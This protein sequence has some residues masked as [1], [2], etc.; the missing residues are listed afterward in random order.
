MFT[1]FGLF[2]LQESLYAQCL[3]PISIYPFQEDFEAGPAG[4]VSGGT[5]SDWVL[6]T[7]S[8]PVIANA[9]SGN[10]CW[11]T[12]GL[13]TSFYSYGERSWVMSPCFDLSTLT[14]PV[15]S[16]SAFWDTEYLYD[17][18]NFQYSIDGGNS[19]RTLGAFS[20]PDNCLDQNWYNVNSVT[21][22]SGITNDNQGWAGTTQNTSGSCRG[23]HGSGQWMEAKHCLAV[24]AGQS[25]VLFR[26][27][28]GSG[29]TCNDYDGFAFDLFRIEE[30]TAVPYNFTWHCVANNVVQFNDTISTCHTYWN[31]NFGDPGSSGNTSNLQSPQHTYSAPGTYSVTLFAGNEC[32]PDVSASVS[33]FILDITTTSTPETCI[34]AK[35]GTAAVQVIGSPSVNLYTWNTDPIQ[36]TATATGLGAG[37]YAV[38]ITTANACDVD[39]TVRVEIGPDAFPVVE[40]GNDTTLCPGS[41]I[42]L[43]A[44]NFQAYKWQ[45]SSAQ[46]SFVV[47]SGGMYSVR[48]TNSA[49]CTTSDSIFISE[50]CLNELV[51]PNAFTPNEDGINEIFLP[52]GSEVSTY[53]LRIFNRWGQLIFETDD[54]NK[55]WDGRFHGRAQQDGIYLYKVSYGIR[56][57]EEKARTGKLVLI[58]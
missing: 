54:Q 18:A 45:D 42:L 27:T 41:S 43:Q 31:W 53:D 28:F 9:A 40:L 29:T 57:G 30:A 26:F 11:I 52:L 55:G 4:W 36:N 10:N 5:N 21:N 48:I 39:A 56:T 37:D 32:I 33:I 8:K 44:G 24:V 49:G 3:S 58:R 2:H 22:L 20:E 38:N 23:G 35:D 51:F 34:N 50:D 14:K 12:G 15:V 46:S 25:Q 13:N 17:G 7:P 6:G 16:F 47:E 1:A 19:W